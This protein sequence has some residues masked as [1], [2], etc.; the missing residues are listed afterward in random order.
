MVAST[1]RGRNS[2]KDDGIRG[3]SDLA[4]MSPVL[5][6]PWKPYAAA[7]KRLVER[8]LVTAL[9]T[10][11]RGQ[12]PGSWKSRSS[13]KDFPILFHACQL[14]QSTSTVL[15][16]LLQR[17]TFI[18]AAWSLVLSHSPPLVHAQG[19]WP[20]HPICI[21]CPFNSTRRTRSW[22]RTYPFNGWTRWPWTNLKARQ[23][24]YQTS[25]PVSARRAPCG[26][27][28]RSLSP[29][30]PR[31]APMLEY[32]GWERFDKCDLSMFCPRG[33]SYNQIDDLSCPRI[34]HFPHG[35]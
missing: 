23:D 25:R 24:I 10:N 14:R 7:D 9:S 21:V 32:V 35:T 11:S 12:Q 18:T 13:L 1:S 19:V 33:H 2:V 17:E 3:H 34:F 28:C 8:E 20:T 5:D 30:L 15:Y 22:F 16:S 29:H 27:C 31:C 4:G 6:V 26:A